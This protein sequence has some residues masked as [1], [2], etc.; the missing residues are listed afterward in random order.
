MSIQI[1]LVVR[2][3]W[4]Y[5]WEGRLKR[6]AV[7][8]NPFLGVKGHFSARRSHACY[9]LRN[10]HLLMVSHYPWRVTGIYRSHVIITA[11]TN[12]STR[13]ASARA[14]VHSLNILVK[15]V[16]LY[17]L[18]HK[19]TEGQF[20]RRVDRTAGSLAERARGSFL[21]V[22]ENNLCWVS[23]AG[24]VPVVQE[25]PIATNTTGGIG[26]CRGRRSRRQGFGASCTSGSFQRRPTDHSRVFLRTIAPK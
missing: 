23:G 15:Y 2:L 26:T 22:S 18:N 25:S 11:D 6:L 8:R 3:I 4:G 24:G 12:K 10:V 16:R 9:Y 1:H 7:R 21:G 17:G 19:R 13:I 14:F 5:A 20:T